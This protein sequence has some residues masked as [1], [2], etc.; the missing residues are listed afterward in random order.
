MSVQMRY[1][2][3]SLQSFATDTTPLANH[4]SES[5]LRQ[6]QTKKV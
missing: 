2:F 6:N 3:G 1:L 4:R 5:K